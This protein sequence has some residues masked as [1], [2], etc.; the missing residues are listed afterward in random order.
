MSANQKPLISPALRELASLRGVGLSYI[1]GRGAH[2]RADPDALVAILNSFGD[3]DQLSLSGDARPVLR[4]HRQQLVDRILEPVYVVDEGVETHMPIRLGRRSAGLECRLEFEFGGEVSWSLS[5]ES[6]AMMP[7]ASANDEPVFALA[8]PAMRVGYHHIHVAVGRREARST[9]IVRPLRGAPYRFARDWRAYSVQAPIFSLHSKRSWGS[10]DVGDLDEFARLAA[11]Q[12]ATVVSTLPLLAS[13]GPNDFESS[14]YRPVSRRFWNDRWIAL[15]QVDDLARSPAAQHLMNDTYS[16]ARREVWTVNGLVDGGAAFAAKRNVIQAWAATQSEF[17]AQHESG[18]R[19]Y[20]MNHPDLNDYA[21]FRAAGERFGLD[22]H[23]WPST[24]RSG[25]LRWNDVD[26]ILVRY[27][28]FAQWIIDEQMTRLASRLSQRGQ[29]LELDIPVGVHPYGYDVWRNPEDYVSTMSIGAPPDDL[30]A[31]GQDWGSPPPHPDRCREDAHGKFRE[32]LRFHMRIAGVV[33]IDHV[34]GLQRLFWVPEGTSPEQGLYVAMPFEEQLAVVAIEAQRLG[35]DVV[36]EDLGT[37]EDDLRNAMERDG[38]RRTYV[39]QYAITNEGLAPV[40]RGSVASFATHDTATF[41]GW[42]SGADIDERLGLGLFD[43]PAAASARDKRADQRRDLARALDCAE[44]DPPEVVLAAVHAF[45][46]DS[47]AGLVMAQLDDLLEETSAV[48]LPGTTTE[49]ANWNRL[50]RLSLEELASS[51][52]LASALA[53]LRERRGYSSSKKGRHNRQMLADAT[54]FTEQDLHLLNEGRHFRLYHHLGCHRM[55][56]EGVAGCY[57][58]VWAPNADRVSVIGEFN[59]WDGTQHQLAPVGSS[60][61]WEGFIPGVE[62]LTTY[63]YRLHS[64]LGGDEF[65][66]T[67]P[68]GRFFE[69]PSAT[70]TRVWNSNYTWSD[71]RW[72]DDRST[73]RPRE[74]PVSVYEVHLGSWRRVPEEHD[75]QL[76]YRELAPLLAGYA[77]EMGFTHVELLPVMEHPFYGSWGYQTTGYFAPTSRMGTPDDFKYLVDTLHLAGIGVLLDWVPSHFPADEFALARFDGTHLYEHADVRQRVHPD[78]QSWTFNY[79]RNEVRSFLIS[80]ACFW[81]DE[82]HIDG[83]RLDAVASMLYLDYSRKAGEWVPNKYGGHE[84]LEAVEFLRQCTTELTESFPGVIVVAEE[85]TSW[86][87]VT[88][89]VFEDGL[90]FTFKWDLGWMHDTLDYLSRDAVHR[91][92]HQNE[93]TFRAIYAANERFMLPLSHDEVVH[94]KGSLLAKMAGDDWQKRANLRLLFGYQYTIPGKKLLF[95][96]DEFAQSGEW[97]H[98]RSLDWHLLG[99]VEHQG[100]AR[101][102]RRLN[103]LYS[104]NAALH[105]DDA[106]AEDFAWLSCDDASQSVLIW[107]RGYGPDELVMLANFTPVPRDNYELPITSSGNWT[108]VL[109]SD[110]HD[111]G[112]SGY[113]ATREFSSSTNVH[114]GHVLSVSLPPLSLVV[115]RR[116]A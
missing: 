31:K 116:E 30:S 20:V 72:I 62:E 90:G 78:W 106:S 70:A 15:D 16:P 18:L 102:V 76:T 52:V 105:R 9:I 104:D 3:M 85:S 107:R 55:V 28:M 93:L 60:G 43:A 103:A 101:W 84:D 83:L 14:P 64:R 51:T 96:G 74:R 50:A 37:V 12:Q 48:N 108:V 49:R 89:P 26:P 63:K 4:Q 79:G 91:K 29:T 86:P 10:G 80:S 25:M 92:Y 5:S 13:F 42:W 82:Y 88:R 46:A 73:F 40:P 41:S 87:A 34:M 95:M 19:S 35:V 57:F 61:V 81:L 1:D 45:L 56:F 17:M 11:N 69:I 22:F 94:G 38:L 98:E 99:S 97:D 58:A 53:P 75:R 115:L 21:R 114:S 109:N 68:M 2:R 27:H 112:G 71:D 44:N 100:V 23:K 39:A 47:D 24:A 77:V 66:K 59:D 54:R 113:L 7:G 6:L 32:A 65:D 33:R 67:D 36:G 111:Y 8:L 110:D